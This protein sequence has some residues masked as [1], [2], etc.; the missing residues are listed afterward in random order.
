MM[1]KVVLWGNSKFNYMHKYSS[2]DESL[3]ERLRTRG[4]CEKKSCAKNDMSIDAQTEKATQ[5]LYTL[6]KTS[7]FWAK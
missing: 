6:I 4:K 3:T 1:C 7:I 5:W 2:A